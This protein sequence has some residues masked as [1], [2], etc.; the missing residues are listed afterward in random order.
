MEEMQ[1]Y[2][3]LSGLGGLYME[4]CVETL[5]E[6]IERIKDINSKYRNILYRGQSNMN[7]KIESAAYR[8]LGN[9]P[10]ETLKC[11]TMQLLREARSLRD[12]SERF[13][14]IELLAYLQHE[15]AKTCLIDYSRNPLIALFFAC[16]T[17]QDTDGIV[18]GLKY[19][20][21]F[22]DF[23]LENPY[24]IDELFCYAIDKLSIMGNDEY[25][26]PLFPYN[27][28][29][30]PPQLNRRIIFQQGVLIFNRKGK[31]EESLNTQIIIPQKSKSKIL[32]EL[33]LIGIS[34]KT[35][36]PDSGGLS[37]WFTYKHSEH[38]DFLLKATTRE[39]IKRN[40][41]YAKC[42]SILTNAIKIAENEPIVHPEIAGTYCDR[43]YAYDELEKYTDAVN[44]YTKAIEIDPEY[45]FAYNNRGTVYVKQ[46]KYQNAINDFSKAIELNPND[47]FAYNNRGIVFV[48]CGKIQNAINDFNCAIKI[49]SNDLYAYI[50]LRNLYR[51]QGNKSL[52]NKYNILIEQIQSMELLS[53]K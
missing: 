50:N 32:E 42:I 17:Q 51:N 15:G 21:D 29:I 35:L 33:E 38:Y 1:N 37:S 39:L 11:Y 27:Y 5:T 31:L 3:G 10:V 24:S 40:P 14:D 6:Y 25:S 41:D 30:S 26:Y 18:F 12:I 19:S 2:S 47:T 44:D 13:T 52:E 7:W 43:G 8:H 23:D 36:F 46:K 53:Y 16:D 28:L 48:K 22:V 45:T 9:P 20:R 4:N 49:D 34:K